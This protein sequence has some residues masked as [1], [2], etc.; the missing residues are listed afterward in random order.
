MK[1]HETIIKIILP[2]I[3]LNYQLSNVKVYQENLTIR[4]ITMVF[5][6]LLWLLNPLFSIMLLT[7]CLLI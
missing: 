4:I 5:H 1:Y 7:I 2:N 6:L 3:A